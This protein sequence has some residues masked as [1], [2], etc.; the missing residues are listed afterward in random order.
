MAHNVEQ[1]YYTGATLKPGL[2]LTAMVVTTAAA[3]AGSVVVNIAGT[4]STAG[5]DVVTGQDQRPVSRQ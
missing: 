4:V 5:V 1:W 3:A 2:A